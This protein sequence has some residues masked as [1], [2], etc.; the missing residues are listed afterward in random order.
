M[1]AIQT[2][3]DALF[4]T[5]DCCPACDSDSYDRVGPPAP[6]GAVEVAGRSFRQPPFEARCCRRCHLVF[7]S[8]VAAP[9]I[10][11]DYY[12][13]ID[14]RQW[15]ATAL[16]PTE[17]SIVALLRAL[18]AGSRVMDFGC[19]SGRLLGEVAG[20][21]ECYGFEINVDAARAAAARGITILPLTFL[22][23]EE[24]GLGFD[25][26]VLVD[27]FEH[28]DHPLTVLRK[29]AAKLRPGGWLVVC[30]GNSDAP[31]VRGEPAL[32]WYFELLEH[33]C[34]LNP[35]HGRFIASELGLMLVREEKSC[36]YDMPWSLRV[37][38]RIHALT[39]EAFHRA[40]SRWLPAVLGLVP[41]LRNA[42]R[43]TTRPVWNS[44][45]DHLVL[46]FRNV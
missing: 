40:R 36:H 39:F 17:R 32:F 15:E 20:Q 24:P 18:P 37:R 14:Y 25:A 29:V 19:S 33:L 35:A 31:P 30:T 34:M 27:V 38:Q 43:W 8:V 22:D 21:H 10:L 23:D 5:Q 45:A 7:K 4:V 41:K 1:S 44:A 26:A 3:T 13:R 16:Y 11:A 6:G 46:M 9:N 12:R 2:V 28:L 42:R